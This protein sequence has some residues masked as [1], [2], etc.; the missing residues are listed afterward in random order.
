VVLIVLVT[1]LPAG[2]VG[3]AQRLSARLK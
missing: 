1:F 2:V 3:T